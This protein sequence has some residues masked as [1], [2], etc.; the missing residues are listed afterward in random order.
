VN[1]QELTALYEQADSLSALARELNRP[2]HELEYLFRKNNIPLRRT[3]FKSPR[4][5]PI[6]KGDEHYNWKRGFYETSGYVFEYAPEHPAS[7]TR[8]GYV[9]QH[10][11]VMEKHL[12][13]FLKSDELVHHINGNK[14]DNR[15]ENLKLLSRSKHIKIHKQDAPRDN[16]GRFT[17]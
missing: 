14:K 11:L 10:R 6:P 9:P 12:G 1:I 4:T 5:V 13:R 8:K 17:I 2:R 16:K 7:Q 15:L 3:G